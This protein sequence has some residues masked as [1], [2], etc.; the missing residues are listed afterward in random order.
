[1]FTSSGHSDI[2]QCLEVVSHRVTPEMN[3][4][5]LRP[6]THEEVDGALAHMSPL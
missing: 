3:A 2:D 1:L 5:L 6:F 4:S